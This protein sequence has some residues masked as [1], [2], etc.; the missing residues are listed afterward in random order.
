MFGLWR[1]LARAVRALSR[2]LGRGGGTTLPGR[3][4][5]RVS[6][7]ALDR[8]REELDDGAAVVSATNGK[9]T[10][11]AMVAAVLE[12]SGEQVVHN[13]AGSN[14]GWGVA[15][16]LLDARRGTGQLGLFEV[17]EAWLPRVARSLH[18]GTYLLSNLFRDQLDRY[19]ELETL[20]EGWAELVAEQT[21]AA[22]FV[23]NADDPLIAD[24]GR[25]REGVV[26][27]GIGDDSQALPELQHAADSKHCRN[28]GAAYVYDAVYLGHLG[29]YRCPGCGRERPAPAVEATSVELEGMRGARATIRTPQ[30]TIDVTLP[31]PGLYNVYN[32]VGATA[33]ALELGASLEDARAALE[34]FGGAFGRVETIAVP[35]PEGARPLSILLIKNPAGANEVLRTVAL[36]DEQLD[37]WIALNDRT[38]DGRDVSWIWDADFELLAGRVRHVTCSGTRA[39]EMALRLKYAG[40]D[41]EAAVDRDLAASLDAAVAAGEA[42]RPLYAL[43]TYTALLELRELLSRRGLAPRWA[44]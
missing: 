41:A 40:V 25:D 38:A 32:A 34:G 8:M 35:G 14:M 19:G 6:P 11:A 3:L 23:L 30:G 20:A 7:D 31:L 36:E 15:T 5:L 42:G 13:R 10:T 43:P 26:Y 9:T 39:E 12:R 1:L 18:P 21:G 2:L 37:V 16:A 44:D 24:L 33:L 4:L 27:F 28:C 17:D 29:R 22:R